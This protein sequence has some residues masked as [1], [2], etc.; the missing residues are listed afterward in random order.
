MGYFEGFGVTIRQHRLFGGKRVTTNY[1]GGRTARRK[2]DDHNPEADD[3]QKAPKP[4]RLHGRHVLNRYADGMEKCIGCELCAGVCPAQCI[5]VRGEDN[6]EDN[7]VSPGE[8]YGFIYEINML[9]CI[10]CALCVEACPTEAIT[11]TSLFEMSVAN[12]SEAIFD[13]DVLVVKDD[14]TPNTHENQTKLTNVD[15][16]NT[17]DGWMRA[18][19]PNGNPNF[20]NIVNWSGSLGVGKKPPEEGQTLEEE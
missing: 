18:T 20:Q 5:Y 10:Y 6:P 7:P 14:G 16:L 9:R 4:E 13:K 19:S 15:D 8:R 17:S 2:G 11:M 3:D 12:R 1:S